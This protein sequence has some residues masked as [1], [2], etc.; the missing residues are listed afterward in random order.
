[1]NFLNSTQLLAPSIVF[2]LGCQSAGSSAVP[3]RIGADRMNEACIVQMQKFI[4]S[5]QGLGTVLTPAAFAQNDNLSIV[6]APL[7][8]KTGQLAQGREREMPQNYRLNKSPAGCTILRE[9]DGSSA[10][11]DACNCVPLR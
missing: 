2:L 8:D 4:T 10:L 1:M 11:L 7:L 3:A 6:A 5:K 9:S